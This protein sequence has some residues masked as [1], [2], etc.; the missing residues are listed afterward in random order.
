MDLNSAVRPRHVIPSTRSHWSRG[1]PRV[2]NTNTR[3]LCSHAKQIRPNLELSASEPR[4]GSN[5]KLG[6][7][8]KTWDG[9]YFFTRSIHISFNLPGF[10]K[11]I[12]SISKMPT[13]IMGI[14]AARGWSWLDNGSKVDISCSRV[15]WSRSTA[16]HS[17]NEAVAGTQ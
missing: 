11:V 3:K 2:L 5:F 17:D 8:I 10:D 15:I 4:I 1:Q 7:I 12:T 13:N 6:C 16:A 9:K 14:C